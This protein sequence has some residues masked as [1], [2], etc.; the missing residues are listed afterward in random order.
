MQ[1]NYFGLLGTYILL[2]GLGFVSYDYL[3]D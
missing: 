2:A 1:E 3:L